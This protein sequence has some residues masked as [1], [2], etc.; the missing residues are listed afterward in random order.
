MSGQTISIVEH[1]F[2]LSSAI[3]GQEIL[4]GVPDLFTPDTLHESG[5]SPTRFK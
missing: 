1:K 2:K 3:L 4:Q 5:F